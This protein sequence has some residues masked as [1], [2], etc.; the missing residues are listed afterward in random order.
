MR[1]GLLGRGHH[2]GA[3]MKT[4]AELERVIKRAIAGHEIDEWKAHRLAKEAQIVIELRRDSRWVSR[5]LSDYDLEAAP[6]P[7]GIVKHYLAVMMKEL[8]A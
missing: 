3:A 2:L 6:D 8:G 7:A 1:N 4:V 5:A